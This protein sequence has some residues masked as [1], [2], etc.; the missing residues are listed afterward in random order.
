M[1]TR[2]NFPQLLSAGLMVKAWDILEQ[3]PEEFSKFC[4]VQ[5]SDKAYEQS[6]FLAGLGL[7]ILKRE[8]EKK[9][10]TEPVQGGTKR[11]IHDTYALAWACTKEMLADDQYGKIRQI[12]G[13]LMPSMKYVVEQ[14]AANILNLGFTTVTTVDG[15]TLFNTAHALLG[16]EGGT[17][18]NQHAT[19]STLSQTALQDVHILGSNFKN[20][21]NQKRALRY[22]TLHIPPELQWVAAKILKS[23]L[24]P[25]TGN[26][27]VNV[28]KGLM[29]IMIHNFF[30]STTAWFCSSKN[31]NYIKFYWRQKPALESADEFD[32]GGTKH[33]IDARF[34]A[35]AEHYAGWAGSTGAGA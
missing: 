17:Q 9:T 25:G 28:T 15:G 32:T 10:Y 14:T 33:S 22:D 23:D 31:T 1:T 21:R 12:P 19:N 7:A 24:E 13:E 29:D 4:K 35:V 34:S 27:D 26:N 8:G 2:G 6:Q 11:V 3:H 18:S 5:T 20:E 30:T 16:P